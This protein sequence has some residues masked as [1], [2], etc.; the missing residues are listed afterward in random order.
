MWNASF[1]ESMLE[2][3]VIIRCPN[4][5]DANEL[6]EIFERNGV[7]WSGGE[8]F[9]GGSCWDGYNEDTCYWVEDKRLSYGSRDYAEYDEN[10]EYVDYIKCTFYGADTPD[11]DVAND[12][13]LCAFLGIGGESMCGS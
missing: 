11:F 9:D 8:P 1:D 3:D 12:D 5:S 7:V 2:N 4:E 6:M 10:G 13:E